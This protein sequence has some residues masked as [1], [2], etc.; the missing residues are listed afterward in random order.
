MIKV[1]GMIMAYA[2][3]QCATV[4]WIHIRKFIILF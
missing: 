1:F 3:C 2:V 4:A